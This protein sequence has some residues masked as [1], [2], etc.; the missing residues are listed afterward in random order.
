M[1][2]WVMGM[3]MVMVITPQIQLKQKK[4]GCR[5]SR[6]VRLISKCKISNVQWAARFHILSIGIGH[7]NNEIKLTEA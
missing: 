6:L 1:V 3:G 4:L 2:V 7:R 5:G